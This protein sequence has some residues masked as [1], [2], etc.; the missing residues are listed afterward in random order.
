MAT[1]AA[2]PASTPEPPPLDR[3]ALGIT[4]PQPA[5]LVPGGPPE[6]EQWR[7]DFAAIA[8]TYYRLVV[9]WWKYSDPSGTR[10]DIAEPQAGCLRDKL[11]CAAYAGLR[12]QL[13]ALA[14][15][16]RAAPGTLVGMAVVLGT[17]EGAAYP[18]SGCER[19]G[20]TPYNR[21]PRPETLGA[22]ERLVRT[23]AAEAARVG[24]SVP[25]WS[26]WNEPNHPYTQSPQRTRCDGDAPSVAA[27]R[28]LPIAR[29]MQRALA[30]VPGEQRLVLGETAAFYADRPT[31]T[32][33]AEFIRALPRD[34]VCDA[35]VYGQHAYVPYRSPVG[36]VVTAL[37]R[38]GCPRTP[39]LWITET[40]LKDPS[41]A[42]CER[43]VRRLRQWARDERVGAVFQY[44]LRNDDLFPTGL[45]GTDLARPYPVLE[46]WKA[47]GQ[48]LRE[49]SSQSASDV[50]PTITPSIQYCERTA[51]LGS[52]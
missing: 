7:D 20:T 50:K 14:A 39:R 18:S 13:E 12:G 28:Y 42:G 19:P 43:V 5:F 45:V 8:P 40:G 22:Y 16:Q 17:P 21:P 38:F 26:P 6:F 1:P 44:T 35:A 46:V 15:A 3:F 34:L 48:A 23:V 11:P 33:T 41:R 49:A 4:E 52:S 37:E 25:Y 9:D 47:W 2:T 29:A 24:A 27:G 30:E 32:P 31:S 10:I 36:T 51:A